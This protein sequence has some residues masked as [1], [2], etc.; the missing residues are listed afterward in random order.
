MAETDDFVPAHVTADHPL[1]LP[2]LE[3]LI[4]D[5]AAI[6]EVSR[7]VGHELGKIQ[8][9]WLA[10]AP[11]FKNDGQIGRLAGLFDLPHALA[12][13]APVLLENARPMLLKT[14]RKLRFEG[15]EGAIQMRI[16]PQPRWRVA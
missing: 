5:A 10:A 12:A 8:A 9:P 16:V 1:W 13:I 15:V 2:L 6:R 14:R 3:G 11:C 7:T 4:D